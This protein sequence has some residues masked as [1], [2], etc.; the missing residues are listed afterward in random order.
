MP[1]S[2]LRRSISPK[3][4]RKTPIVVVLERMSMRSVLLLAAL[5]VFGSACIYDILPAVGQGGLL[6]AR[7]TV[8]FLDALY[9]SVV[10][11]T[12]LGYGDVIPVGASRLV[13]CAEVILGLTL[14]GLA[15]AKASSARQSYYLR[16]LYVNY[17]TERFSYYEQSLRD[18][19]VA[20]RHAVLNQPNQLQYLTDL[21]VRLHGV[22]H[23]FDAFILFEA[24]Q[25][26][27]LG[28][29]ST[30]SVVKILKQLAKASRQLKKTCDICRDDRQNK[31]VLVR[32]RQR[33]MQIKNTVELVKSCSSKLEICDECDIV[34]KICDSYLTDLST[35]VG[36]HYKADID[37][38]ED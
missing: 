11:F 15:V 12:S 20:Y 8:H 26:D 21:N 17:A 34:Q 23:S 13:A 35:M 30:S 25:G 1:S 2:E 22:L 9:F 28:E 37:L 38:E 36:K 14:F 5:V 19:K 3:S 4:K 7:G 10:T 6:Q 32:A 16:R 29:V 24:S 33:F 31:K 27:F 18:L